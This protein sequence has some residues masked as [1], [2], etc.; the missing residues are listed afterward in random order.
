[1]KFVVTWLKHVKAE[2]GCSGVLPSPLRRGCILQPRAA[3]PPVNVILGL[4]LVW[5]GRDT[6]SKA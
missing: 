4:E 3:P 5:G 1:M 2:V 6:W